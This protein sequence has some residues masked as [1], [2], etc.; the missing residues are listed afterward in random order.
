MR[1]SNIR[2]NKMQIMYGSVEFQKAA[3]LNHKSSSSI[4]R[5]IENIGADE[6]NELLVEALPI[7]V[8]RKSAILKA[9]EQNDVKVACEYAHRTTGS[10]RLYGSSRLEDLL[11]EVA[12]LSANQSQRSGL[13]TELES[14]FNSVIHEVQER[15]KVGIS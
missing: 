15:L 4:D 3:S 12:S 10:I 2:A 14:E 8:A 9:L 11:L 13:Q 1:C 7:I 6:S 5:L